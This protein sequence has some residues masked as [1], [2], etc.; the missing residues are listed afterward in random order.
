[1]ALAMRKEQKQWINRWGEK[2]GLR[3]DVG[4]ISS[5]KKERRKKIK[6]KGF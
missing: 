1:M 5:I 3:G 4:L 6:S 2:Q